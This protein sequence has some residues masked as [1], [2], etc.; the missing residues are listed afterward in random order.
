MATEIER[1][2]LVQPGWP[3]PARGTRLV[4]GYLSRGGLVSVRVRKSERQAWLTVK[5]PTDGISRAEFEYEV[6]PTDADEMLAL[7]VTALI[8]K[9]RYLVPHG[10]HVVEVD[11]FA[12]ANAGLVV[13]EVEFRSADESFLPPPWCGVEV[14]SDPRYRNSALAERPFTTWE[15]DTQ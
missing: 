14:T 8:E 4:Q 15:R 7:A 11:V 1:K 6:P 10:P 9:T 2:F 12:G 3:Q 13:A 5:G